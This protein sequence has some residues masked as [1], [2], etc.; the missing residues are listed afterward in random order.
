MSIK[1]VRF[2]FRKS[3]LLVQVRHESYS[4]YLTIKEKKRK[5]MKGRNAKFHSFTSCNEKF[6][7]FPFPV[8]LREFT[9]K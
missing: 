1:C 2:D 6:V 9:Y 3:D 7:L 8:M 4:Y 5:A